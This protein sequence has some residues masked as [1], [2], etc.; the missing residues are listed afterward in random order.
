VTVPRVDA[1]DDSL[2]S[3]G[4]L[5]SQLVVRARTRRV[6]DSVPGAVPSS[7]SSSFFFFPA[8]AGRTRRC[9]PR[10]GARNGSVIFGTSTVAGVEA[11]D[12]SP[13]RRSASKGTWT[14]V[15]LQRDHVCFVPPPVGSEL[16]LQENAI[17]YAARATISLRAWNPLWDSTSAPDSLASS[18]SPRLSHPVHRLNS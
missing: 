9:P 4:R 17:R 10:D 13:P 7:S 16:S 1:C 15:P 8:A 18:I 12:L 5:S 2:Q 14:R 11:T 3:S 6:S